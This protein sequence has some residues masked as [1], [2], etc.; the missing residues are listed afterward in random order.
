MNLDH[1][2]TRRN[3]IAMR[4][5]FGAK[6]PAGMRCSNLV[7]QLENLRTATGE[8]KAALEAFIKEQMA[9]LAKLTAGE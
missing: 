8:Q 4:L 7:E 5:K 2:T 3:L 9:D 6:T 1:E